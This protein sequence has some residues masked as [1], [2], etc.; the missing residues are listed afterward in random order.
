MSNY[1]V[2]NLTNYKCNLNNYLLCFSAPSKCLG[3]T[4]KLQE[5]YL[6]RNT[7][8]YIELKYNVTYME[9]RG[10]L[11]ETDWFY[12]ETYC[13]LNMFRAPL[14]PSSGAIELY[15]WLLLVVLGSLVYRLLVWCG[16]VGYVSCLQENPANR[17]HNPD[18]PANRTHKPQF[19]GALA[20]V[21]CLQEKPANR[22]HNPDSPANRTH[23]ACGTWL[24]GL[25]VIGLVWSCGL[26]VLFVG[27]SRKPVT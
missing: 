13:L 6:Q 11:N 15:R 3:P 8:A 24:F 1:P 18:S 5:G 22:A 20:Y 17:T 23:A 14:R 12:C 7:Y 25:Q 9:I 26:C 21:S 16:A 19:H 10:Q 2:F 27:E 4:G